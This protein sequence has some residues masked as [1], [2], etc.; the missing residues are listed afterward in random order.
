MGVGLTTLIHIFSP[1][2]ILIGGGV[3]RAG[4]WILRPARRAVD[5]LTA[6]FFRRQLSEIKTTNLG[7]N[8]R[9]IGAAGLIL[10]GKR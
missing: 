7:L 5:S 4:E 6:P 1:E 9:V 8:A 10:F 2:L 3:S